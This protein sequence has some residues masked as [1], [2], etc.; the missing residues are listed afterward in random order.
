MGHYVAKFST[1]GPMGSN[2]VVHDNLPDLAR[3]FVVFEFPVVCA[4]GGTDP[5][6]AGGVRT[7]DINMSDLE[8]VAYFDKFPPRAMLNFYEGKVVQELDVYELSDSG[9]EKV[10]MRRVHAEKVHIIGILWQYNGLTHNPHSSENS[11][12]VV[13]VRANLIE[14]VNLSVSKDLGPQGN[15]GAGVNTTRGNI[16]TATT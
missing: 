2:K 16:A 10:I 3:G 7:E 5:S 11:I 1:D 13:Q 8:L 9:G 12:I 6:L 14:Q 15:V 4:A